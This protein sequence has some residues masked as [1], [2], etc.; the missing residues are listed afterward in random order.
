MAAYNYP[1]IVEFIQEVPKIASGKVLKRVLRER[2]VALK[3]S[4]LG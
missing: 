4:A 1:R 2:E 3:K